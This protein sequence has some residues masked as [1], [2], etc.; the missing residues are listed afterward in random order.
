M[1]SGIVEEVGRVRSYDMQRLVIEA[2][3]VLSDLRVSDSISVAGVCLTVIE[4]DDNSFSVDTVPET[5]NRSNFSSLKPGDGVNLERALSYGDRVGGHMV[6]GHVDATGTIRSME[7]DGNSVWLEIECP[8]AI[9]K[10]IVEKGFISVDGASLTVTRVTADSFFLAIIPFTLENT[11]LK[12]REVGSG[13]NI[14]VDVTA[15]YVEKFVQPHLGQTG[16]TA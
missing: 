1:F 14:E 9:L 3:N 4:K 10:Y 6:Q 13:V 11:T 16:D 8:E 15:K 7:R 5:V 2:K 12:E